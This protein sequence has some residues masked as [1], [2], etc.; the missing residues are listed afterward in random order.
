MRDYVTLPGVTP[1]TPEA[2]FTLANL[3]RPAGP[4]PGARRRR[5]GLIVGLVATGAVIL[6]GGGVLIGAALNRPAAPKPTAAAPQVQQ[7]PTAL[8]PTTAAAPSPT[9]AAAHRAGETVTWATGL[10]ATAYAFSAPVAKS[11]EKPE[12]AGYVWGAIDI[13]VC[14]PQDGEISSTSWYLGFADN[15]TAEPSNVTYSQF[16]HPVYPFDR[17]VAAGTCT[18]G[19]VTFPVPAAQKPVKI[20][21]SNSNGSVP[22]E[23]LI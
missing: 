11:A 17:T 5:T 2:P 12:Q 19:W 16:P 4:A 22:T 23:W 13:Q 20:V 3:A 8:D 7:Q 9:Q 21:Y 10:R 6:A 1:D 14:V 15:T 18:R